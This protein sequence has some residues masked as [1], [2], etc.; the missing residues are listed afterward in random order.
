MGEGYWQ[1]KRCSACGAE[2]RYWC[3]AKVCRLCAKRALVYVRKAPARW[4]MG[5]DDED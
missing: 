5:E 4:W 3:S 1:V 2:D